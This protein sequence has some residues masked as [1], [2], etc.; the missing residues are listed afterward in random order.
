MFKVLIKKNSVTQLQYGMTREQV[1]AIES[2]TIT[3]R[4]AWQPTEPNTP[5]YQPYAELEA[6]AAV[7]PY[8]SRSLFVHQKDS[9]FS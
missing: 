8:D 1:A 3:H 7:H 4:L 2:R 9:Y 6:H 5:E